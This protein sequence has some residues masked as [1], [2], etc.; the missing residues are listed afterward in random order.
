MPRVRLGVV[1]LLPTPVAAEIDGLRRALGDGARR[2]VPPH[3]TL[4]PPVNVSGDDVDAAVALVR[5]AAGRAGGP[6][7]LTIGPAA[8]FSPLTPVLY[9]T[10]EGDTAR[11]RAL[12][13]AVLVGPLGRPAEWPF[14]P[15]VTI[16]SEAPPERLHAAVAALADFDA[17]VSLDRV[18][19]LQEGED[20]VW[21]PLADVALGPP[22]VIGR[23]GLP[24]E[25]DVSEGLD[26]EAVRFFQSAWRSYETASYGED[27]VAQP[28]AVTARRE[29][30]VVGV[31][32][33]STAGSGGEGRLDRF[34]VS[35]TVR[36]QGIGGHLLSAVERLARQRGC[37]RVVLVAQ[38]GG[39]AQAFYAARG[40]VVERML[41]NW[42]NGRDFVRMVRE[43]RTPEGV[44]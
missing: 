23:G 39:A 37:P 42:R 4:V 12:R 36:R 31:A 8:T 43:L 10:V 24:V 2:F 16:A 40:W 26:P 25:L 3:I 18:H 32:V 38:A 13:D 29:G 11:L 44:R 6:L 17:T 34:V 1:L 20:R 21:A 19:V 41:P 28:F 33:G 9:L 5:D 27:A 22:A 30:D 35:G 14:V 7:E 15:H